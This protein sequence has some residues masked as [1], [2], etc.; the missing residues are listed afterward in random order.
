LKLAAGVLER[1][2]A[3]LWVWDS[4]SEFN[5]EEG[6]KHNLGHVLYISEKNFEINLAPIKMLLKIF[7]LIG[8]LLEKKKRVC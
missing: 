1:H 7:S 5:V 2:S 6:P 3:E 8:T 4:S